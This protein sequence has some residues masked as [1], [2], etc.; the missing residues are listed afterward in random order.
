[1]RLQRFLTYLVLHSSSLPP[2]SLIST[3]CHLYPLKAI[4]WSLE[5]EINVDPKKPLGSR[6]TVSGPA[7]Q[8]DPE[9]VDVTRTLSFTGNALQ[10]PNANSSQML[11]WW[12]ANVSEEPRV[13]VKPL[14]STPA[15]VKASQTY[16][17]SNSRHALR[18]QS[19]Y[20]F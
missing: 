19:L 3:S 16:Q 4:S 8:R 6:V 1:M 14:T 12:P 7:Q 11:I 18:L 15:V 10:P 5:A 2:N 9:I 20:H 13:I 17:H